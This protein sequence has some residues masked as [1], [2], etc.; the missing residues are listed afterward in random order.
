MSHSMHALVFVGSAFGPDFR[1]NDGTAFGFYA[2]GFAPDSGE[3]LQ[4]EP[5]MLCCMPLVAFPIRLA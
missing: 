4:A 5:G 1:H 2:N 3:Q